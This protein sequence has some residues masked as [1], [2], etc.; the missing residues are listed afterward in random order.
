MA[1]LPVSIE[2]AASRGPGGVPF[3]YGGFFAVFQDPEQGV[4]AE[5]PDVDVFLHVGG[6]GDVVGARG[7][8]GRHWLGTVGLVGAG[9]GV[10]EGAVVP[11]EAVY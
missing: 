3:Y 5:F 2:V 7:R 4:G 8:G 10:A 9:G 6:G 1:M 11:A